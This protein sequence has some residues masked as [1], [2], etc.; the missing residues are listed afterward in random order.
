MN[1]VA[2][3]IALILTV[4]MIV[5][6]MPST[7]FGA[8]VPDSWY[9]Q[10]KAMFPDMVGMRDSNGNYIFDTVTK[11][12][13]KINDI[14][15]RKGSA[16]SV[17]VSGVGTLY[18]N[19]YIYE[20]SAYF[21]QLVFGLPL[22]AFVEKTTGHMMK[23]GKLGEYK[24]LGYDV[25]GMRITNDLYSARKKTTSNVFYTYDVTEVSHTPREGA[26]STWHGLKEV[27]KS[28]LKNTPFYDDDFHLG[29]SSPTGYTLSQIFG[30]SIETMV[31]VQSPVGVWTGASAVFNSKVIG[32]NTVT[33]KPMSTFEP[34]VRVFTENNQTNFT[35]KQGQNEITINVYLEANLKA[36][37]SNAPMEYLDRVIL[38]HNSQIATKKISGS[39]TK[40]T[41]DE[42]FKYTIRRSD[43]KE[44][45]T[46]SI[47]LS[48]GIEVFSFIPDE[49]S[50]QASGNT[51]INVTVEPNIEPYVDLSLS[52]QYD[53]VYKYKTVN[54][55]RNL[56][57]E[58][59]NKPYNAYVTKV[60]LQYAGESKI[61]VTPASV[62]GTKRTD[63]V[64]QNSE[65]ST[66]SEVI[67]TYKPT[68]TITLSNG[69]VITGTTSATAKVYK[70]KPAPPVATPTPTPTPKPT[71]TP[72]PTLAPTPIPNNNP[73]VIVSAHTEIKAGSVIMVGAYISDPDNDYCKIDGMYTQ[74]AIINQDGGYY[75]NVYWDRIHVGKTKTLQ[76]WGTDSRGGFAYDEKYINI[77]EPTVEN[78]ILA[79]GQKKINR[80]NTFESSE[81][82][83]SLFP[84]NSRQW[85]IV[86]VSGNATADAIKCVDNL[87]GSKSI[88]VLFKKTGTYKVTC[89]VKNTAGCSY[90]AE[91]IVNITDDEPPVAV[92]DVAQINIREPEHGYK[93]EVVGYNS[94][95][96]KDLDSIGNIQLR[97]LYDS[98][99][100]GVFT[101]EVYTT[102]YTG[103]NKN[104][105]KFLKS[106]IGKYRLE[107]TVT[108]SFTI[109][110][111]LSSYVSTS[112]YKAS[113]VTVDFE[114]DNI[115]PFI[116]LNIEK[117]PKIDVYVSV[118]SSEH[119]TAQVQTALNTVLKPSLAAEGIDANIVVNE[120]RKFGLNNARIAG[121]YNTLAVVNNSGDLYV[122]GSSLSGYPATPTK[123]TFFNKNVKDV[124][125]YGSTTYGVITKDNKFY[126]R[127]YDGKSL[128]EYGNPPAGSDLKRVLHPAN[129]TLIAD[130][131]SQGQ[132]RL[133]PYAYPT[134][135][136]LTTSGE[137]YAVGNN[138]YYAL[139]GY[140]T[141]IDREWPTQDEIEPA[142][143]TD[144]R[145][146]EIPNNR[147]IQD[148]IL[149]TEYAAAVTTDNLLYVWGYNP[150][151]SGYRFL[152][153]NVSDS[154][155]TSPRYRSGPSTVKRVIMHGSSSRIHFQVLGTDGRLYEQNT[156]ENRWD[157]V[158]TLNTYFSDMLKGANYSS[159]P[160]LKKDAN[161][162]YIPSYFTYNFTM[163][164]GY[165][166][167]AAIGLT[168]YKGEWAVITTDG[169]L[170]LWAGDSVTLGNSSPAVIPN[171]N[172]G[173]YTSN[174]IASYIDYITFRD[175]AEKYF[176]FIGDDYIDGLNSTAINT[177]GTKLSGWNA[178]FYGLGSS[179]N[180]SQL[181]SIVAKNGGRGAYIENANLNTAFTQLKSNIVDS[182]GDKM[183]EVIDYITVGRGV[184]IST[185][186]SDYENDPIYD[187]QCQI[188]HNPNYFENSIGHDPSSGKIVTSLPSVFNYTGEYTLTLQARDNPV[189]NSA[190][191]RYRKLSNPFT[192]KL[193]VH[194]PPVP[195]AKVTVSKTSPYTVTYW[196]DPYDMDHIS[197]A[198]KGIVQKTWYYKKST[199]ANWTKGQ[200]STIN[201]TDKYQVKYEVMDLE[202]YVASQILDVEVS[203]TDFPPIAQFS[204]NKYNI[205]NTETLVATSTAYDPEGGTL[206]YKWETKKDGTLIHTGT[207]VSGYKNTFASTD[208]GN[209][210]LT[211][212]VTDS[213][214]QSSSFTLNYTVYADNKPPTVTIS[215]S[216][217]S[218]QQNNIQVTITAS[219]TGESAS[220][221]SNI[222][223]RISDKDGLF[224][225]PFTTEYLSVKTLTL[226][227]EGNWYIEAYA[228]DK[229]GNISNI[230][231][232]GPYGIDKTAPDL[233]EYRVNGG[234]YVN[235][236]VYWLAKDKILDIFIKSQE[237]LSGMQYSYVRIPSNH[238]NRAIHYWN[239]TSTNF[240]EFSTSEYTKITDAERVLYDTAKGEY[241]VRFSVKA[242]KDTI[243]PLQYYFTDNVGNI[244][245]YNNSGL[246]IGVDTTGPTITISKT[247]QQRTNAPVSIHVDFTD[248]GSGYSYAEYKLSKSITTPTSWDSTYDDSLD[249]LV[250]QSGQWYLHVRA[251]DKLN[252]MTS[253]SLPYGVY[254]TELNAPTITF[255]PNGSVWKNAGQQ[256]IV[257]A[258][259][260]SGSISSL[261]VKVADNLDRPYS[262]WDVEITNS[263]YI[264]TLDDEGLWY[265]HAEATD[266]VGNTTYTYSNAYKI[267]KTKP[268]VTVEYINGARYV[269][270]NNL[271]AKQG[272]IVNFFIHGFDALSGMTRVL[273]LARDNGMTNPYR[274]LS[275]SGESLAFNTH[276]RI[277]IDA[278]FNITKD[279]N[280][281]KATF[282]FRVLTS[283]DITF[284]IEGIADD[285]ADYNRQG[286][287]DSGLRLITD[288]TPPVVSVDR[289][290]G[291]FIL[292]AP[293]KIQSIDSGSGV[294]SISY[295]ITNS[296]T[297]PAS[298][299]ITV[300]SSSVTA[301]INQEGS[302]Y[303]HIRSY[304]NVD[305]V[306][307]VKTYG[308]YDVIFNRP[309]SIS[310]LGTNPVRI[311]EG[312]NVS[313]VIQVNDVDLQ[314]LTLDIK[315]KNNV[316]T[317][318][319]TNTRSISPSGSSY[320]TL[321]IPVIT[322]ISTG[323]YSIEVTVTDTYG[324]NDTKV[325]N[326]TVAGLSIDGTVGHTAIWELNRQD[327]NIQKSGN[328]NNPRT[329]NTY[330]SGE[331][332][333]VNATTT[334][335]DPSSSVK[336]NTVTVE[337][338]GQGYPALVLSGSG[339]N[340]SGEYWNETMINRWGNTAPESLIFRFTVVYSNGTIKQ[341]DVT[342]VV[343]NREAYY[344]VHQKW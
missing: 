255:T 69:K 325:Y 314:Q 126:I 48:G 197:M 176:C 6:I 108:E 327:F 39:S 250:N 123:D 185:Y 237:K 315:L 200:L 145:K 210:S 224:T 148:F 40:Y 63:A 52:L 215:P 128:Y 168:E 268:F 8:D 34:S 170:V 184:E 324:A 264:L 24:Y 49:K 272:D 142:L 276:S 262:E 313:A 157:A 245:G 17:W 84:V 248:S 114:I 116:G 2:K 318:L 152:H 31:Y 343:D 32:Y 26:G 55:V 312:D 93:A 9:D 165:T 13:Q 337:I 326:F 266:D 56:S 336:P 166:T 103:V 296:A 292:N 20:S 287:L 191:D 329:A 242:L 83:P 3:I 334:Q 70:E 342:V 220:G 288:N 144:F 277:T 129:W 232:G 180:K 92:I 223:Y 206:T 1:K 161:T 140:G 43:L 295:V 127:K 182:F 309:P 228:T 293:I 77:I 121:D 241:G 22:D 254:E 196:A 204:L 252:N 146:I 240:S 105:I 28:Y 271:Y 267:D 30:N 86:P 164:S 150:G 33:W 211:Q 305:N 45:V 124:Y 66:A 335:I 169:S 68:V 64:I 27:Q 12:K 171:F 102:E 159:E 247:S 110:T 183:Q 294:K 235:N 132:V 99:N 253:P 101:D 259:P 85:A 187:T 260:N 207:G 96:S 243:A 133:V 23:D 141:F 7:S 205:K 300:N 317:V 90:V 249:L 59:K 227:N 88:D 234:D 233:L 158:Y 147:A 319:F 239:G 89:T 340:W 188:I 21:N 81:N 155:I 284:T 107:L 298:G 16:T 283:S 94:S 111:K 135:I 263:S 35:L 122:W 320:D 258:T 47:T 57:Y 311:Y 257:Q 37:S 44:G 74:D 5:S 104:E 212:T 198:N 25:Q 282:P 214:G 137:L 80:V 143:V 106:K 14:S 332:F 100:D 58:L 338:L 341:K 285:N 18:I 321:T 172:V 273:I 261:K 308:R 303:L 202:L 67:K 60:E 79:T 4:G 246:Y 61:N 339:I 51:T 125:Y 209:Y 291:S 208:K 265:I 138:Q 203:S 225:A 280:N 175:D 179:S 299:W 186:Y 50:K 119:T 19:P 201:P 251:Y 322:N 244:R 118:G 167:Y 130:N 281:I 46:N 76:A 213:A 151:T 36:G 194:R 98:D 302:W 331:R 53:N 62:I 256:I 178:T 275:Y 120:N 136:Y 231:R 307:D 286:W 78:Y 139:C 29:N 97:C 270:G 91:H 218:W 216:S 160:L 238:D 75:R 131:V 274:G 82:T 193:Y 87:T 279:L 189:N 323:S 113:T 181:E 177:V 11:F 226:S 173:S 289:E 15:L 221:V 134:I 95:Y 328:A 163:P 290:S 306:S 344:K 301:N 149:M 330:W 269:S 112:D 278:P 192:L 65:F 115:A 153:P 304:D 316:G 72:N 10:C 217:V 199:D 162:Y 310:I 156:G 71:S 38:S 190:F 219:D 154:I 41:N 54:V 230:Q 222:S 297:P 229:D 174:N 236:D 117:K 73:M 42:P 195:N 109:P 333:V